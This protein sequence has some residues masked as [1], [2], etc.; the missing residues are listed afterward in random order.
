MM[1]TDDELTEANLK[2][3][4][5]LL[6]DLIRLGV[7]RHQY[8]FSRLCGKGRSYYSCMRTKRHGLNLVG[9]T[10]LSVR[11]GSRIEACQ[12]SKVVAVLRHAQRLVE[13][14]IEAKCRLREQGLWQRA[15]MP[16]GPRKPRGDRHA[17]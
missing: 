14:T 12:D 15:A 16:R 6:Q 5:D 8:D 9:L 1:P 10:V 7:V 3:D 4:Q 2:M 17:D 13:N 11:L